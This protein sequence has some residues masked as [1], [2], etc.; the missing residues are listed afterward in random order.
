MTGTSPVMTGLYPLGE[1]HARTPL[2]GCSADARILLPGD[3][4]FTR[5]P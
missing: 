3:Y 5:R 1:R 4:Q 2:G